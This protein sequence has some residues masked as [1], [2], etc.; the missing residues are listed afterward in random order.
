MQKIQKVTLKKI[1]LIETES[2]YEEQ[3][4]H[5]ETYPASITNYS[6]SMGEKMGLI[7]SS[8]V[9][10]LA[11]LEEVFA[12]AINPSTELDDMRK[13]LDDIDQVKYLKVIY[14]ALIG[15]NPQLKITFDEFT[16]LYHEDIATTIELYS[17]LVMGLIVDRTNKFADNWIKNTKKK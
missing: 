13:M 10:D 8:Q 17:N 2:G 7:K 11:D 5:E 15:L 9:T 1:E 16:K 6:L 4:M 12:T 14:L 3:V